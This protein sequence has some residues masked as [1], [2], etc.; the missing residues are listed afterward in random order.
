MNPRDFQKIAEQLVANNRPAD[1]RTA[2]SRAYYATFNVCSDILRDMGFK[3]PR[4]ATAHGEVRKRLS[5]SGDGEVSRIGSQLG[6]LHNRRLEAD[7]RMNKPDTENKFTVQVIVRQARMM[8]DVIDRCNTEP[9]RSKILS[10]IHE[11]EKKTNS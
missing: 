10:A 6:D 3:I 9:K 11:W 2:V 5:G 8:I 7:Y 4:N 1:L